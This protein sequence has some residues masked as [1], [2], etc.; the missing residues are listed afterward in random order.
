MAGL[1]RPLVA[2]L[3][4]SLA[5]GTVLAAASSDHSV[6]TAFSRVTSDR[7][8]PLLDRL[9]SQALFMSARY[10]PA[11]SSDSSASNQSSFVLAASG[12]VGQT[13]IN[14]GDMSYM[15]P[16]S[17]GTPAQQFT[18]ILDTGS[19][20]LWLTTTQTTPQV[21]AVKKFNS[22]V[23]STYVKTPNGDSVKIQ[24]GS[25]A[26]VGF[27]AEDT[28]SA[29]GFSVTGQDF[30]LA[31]S[32]DS[33]LAGQMGTGT[34]WDGIWGMAFP[35][36]AAGT[37]LASLPIPPFI[38]LGKQF[39][40]STFAFWLDTTGSTGTG[41]GELVLGGCNPNHFTGS[42]QCMSVVPGPVGPDQ[43][44][45]NM[46]NITVGSASVTLP[47]SNRHAILDTGTSFVGLPSA[48][49]SALIPMLQLKTQTTSGGLLAVDCS[50]I[51][52]LPNI[53]FILGT[54]P[55]TLAPGDYIYQDSSMLQP[56]ILGFVNVGTFTDVIL[57]DTFLRKY[58]SVYDTT[59]LQVGL[60]VSSGGQ[61]LGTGAQAS[62]NACSCGASG[63]GQAADPAGG[64]TNLIIG[65][66]SQYIRIGPWYINLYLFI[67][68][69][70]IL[71]IIVLSIAASCLKR[72]RGSRRI[73]PGY[74]SSASP[75][76]MY[77]SG[78]ETSPQGYAT[79]GQY[80]YQH[81]PQ[82]YQYDQYQ[83]YQYEQQSYRN[84]Q[85]PSFVPQSYSPRN[86]ATD[87]ANTGGG[88]RGNPGYPA[89]YQA[90]NGERYY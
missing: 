46:P 6:V 32:L 68:I 31:T 83:R 40:S 85:S 12:P 79:S 19:A 18:V 24:Y 70:G 50:V 82:P 59:N 65:G 47:V 69:C 11:Y 39:S 36:L 44:R 48:I 64:L 86:G 22:A 38:N 78:Y 42:L 87:R 35:A 57:G 16:I 77:S 1:H 84:D 27:L 8:V 58:Y 53:T 14:A 60:A 20:N 63:T 89:Q 28:F 17:M 67:G 15:A 61:G 76:Q 54:S 90:N 33:T 30:M 26:L 80:Q 72:C 5:I 81:E 37:K 71:A 52:T 88:R 66:G 49:Y 51:T 75:S 73:K 2:P 23:S 10:D 62:S 74:N 21:A 41:G 43:W 4:V 29:S 13:L 9:N 56:C 7:K 45:V 34:S 3:A 55:F 25:G